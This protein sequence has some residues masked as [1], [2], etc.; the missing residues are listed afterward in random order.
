MARTLDVVCVEASYTSSFETSD[1]FEDRKPALYKI[2]ESNTGGHKAYLF[3]CG[4]EDPCDYIPEESYLHL[5]V[6]NCDSLA[7]NGKWYDP[8]LQH[9]GAEV[10]GSMSLVIEEVKDKRHLDIYRYTY[11]GDLFKKYYQPL[12][13]MAESFEISTEDL[14]KA[15][16]SFYDE[17]KQRRS[18]KVRACI[19]LA[20]GALPNEPLYPDV[21]ALIHGIRVSHIFNLFGT[22]VGS[23][24]KNPSALI[25]SFSRRC[26]LSIY[27]KHL[28]FLK[29]EIADL[30]WDLK[31]GYCLWDELP[32]NTE[33]Y[34]KL[35]I[36]NGD[37]LSYPSIYVKGYGA[38]P[39]S[40]Y[41][42]QEKV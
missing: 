15:T 37:Y 30:N 21:H 33:L 23:S 1:T 17:C 11:S 32:V 38:D 35:D 10:S 12:K 16:L 40:G 26:P 27:F 25:C 7:I 3:N 34:E 8:A 20:E 41:W 28:D 31:V 18:K 19:D 14:L 39:E 4:Y 2:L 13:E 36:N 9:F 42:F 22:H 6:D 5:S 24:E 29:E